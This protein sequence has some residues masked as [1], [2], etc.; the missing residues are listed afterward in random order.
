[1]AQLLYPRHST[2]THK[3]AT[4]RHMRLCRQ[5]KGAEKY[6][7]AVEPLLE[8]LEEKN[9]LK[10]EAKLNKES[11]K[12]NVMLKDTDLDNSI[13]TLFDKCKAFDRDH[14]GRPILTQLFPDGK[15]STI[16]FASYEEE[17]D[18]AVHLLTRLATLGPDHV[19]ASESQKIND[20]I[21]K[22][23]LALT[24][25][26]EAVKILKNTVANEDIS[27][28][29]L[30]KQYEFNYLDAVKEFGKAFANRLFP[31]ISSGK[32][33]AVNDSDNKE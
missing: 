3:N 31:I 8:D 27:K 28:L 22:C 19:L 33:K 6:A 16:V 26:N 20:N 25:H 24:A 30:E 4:R 17:P 18:M 11:A 2:D 7:I 32:K 14:P 23:R 15:S 21:D 12:D 5:H 29:N 9:R 1:M 13:R 10:E